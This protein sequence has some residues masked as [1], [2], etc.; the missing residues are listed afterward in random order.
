MWFIAVRNREAENPIPDPLKP[1][2]IAA[3]AK[4]V[5]FGDQHLFGRS[6]I[7]SHS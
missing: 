6:F 5:L 7:A 1:T 4:V 3:L 2:E